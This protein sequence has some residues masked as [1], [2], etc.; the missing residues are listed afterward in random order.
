MLT[1]Q[2][3]V[4]ILKRW[5]ALHCLPFNHPTCFLVKSVTF[6]ICDTLVDVGSGKARVFSEIAWFILQC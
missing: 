2:N 5:T 1:G 6:I 3:Q 4:V